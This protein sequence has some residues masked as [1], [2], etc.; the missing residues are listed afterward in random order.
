MYYVHCD[1]RSSG[2]SAKGTPARALQ[3]ITDA[4]DA[5]RD[6][7]YSHEELAYI[8]RLDPGGRPISKAGAYR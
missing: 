3:Y 7:T 1:T 6:P 2:A 8:T 5:E 4:H